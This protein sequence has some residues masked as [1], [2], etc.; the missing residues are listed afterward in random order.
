MSLHQNNVFY[1]FARTFVPFTMVER[2]PTCFFIITVVCRN[3]FE[4][5]KK[6]K[7]SNLF[8]LKKSVLKSSSGS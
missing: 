5:N 6:R 3:D 7:L 2:I 8:D 4:Y 1:T